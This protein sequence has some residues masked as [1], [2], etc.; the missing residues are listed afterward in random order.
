MRLKLTTASFAHLITYHAKNTSF[1]QVHESRDWHSATS[2][3][4]LNVP[5]VLV[6]NEN[7]T[8]RTC[9]RLLCAVSRLACQ[10]PEEGRHSGE[11]ICMTSLFSSASHLNGAAG[12]FRTDILPR[13]GLGNSCHISSQSNFLCDQNHNDQRPVKEMSPEWKRIWQL[14]MQWGEKSKSHSIWV[15]RVW[16]PGRRSVW[17]RLAVRRTL[18]PPPVRGTLIIHD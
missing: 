1:L 11:E 14:R 15:R 10:R 12:S 8:L 3:A 13:R 4:L 7:Q 2:A 6:A 17:A 18:E 16:L 5:Y 9:F